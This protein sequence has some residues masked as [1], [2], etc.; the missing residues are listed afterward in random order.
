MYGA[1]NQKLYKELKLKEKFGGNPPFG[2]AAI[3]IEFAKAGYSVVLSEPNKNIMDEELWKRVEEAGVK[4]VDDDIEA[5]KHGEVNILF[6]PFGKLTVKIAKNIIKYVPENSIIATTCTLH[7]LILHYY[8]EPVLRTKRKDVGISS[9]H[10]AAVPGTELHKHYFIGGKT[11]DNQKLA[12]DEQ[13]N[14]LVE[15][16]KS[17]NKKP[18]VVPADILPAIADMGVLVTAVTLSG[19]LDYYTLGKNVLKAPEEMIEK[20]ILISLYTIASIIET[21]GIPGMVKALNPELIVESAK[22]MKLLD[23]QK[24]LDVAISILSNL[25]DDIKEKIEK[26]KINPTTLVA[27][28]CL[29]KEL[30]NM[31]GERAAKGMIR[32]SQRKL[33][34]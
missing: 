11:L 21:S 9:L 1:G 33:L 8:L 10:P 2:G 23:E 29:L 12:T 20:Q 16:C 22:S 25:N 30:V 3:A 17:V 5:A 31:V 19:I 7:P 4:I 28:Q 27:V 32:R 13:I 34:D 14:K 24:D 6:T 26:A 15:L 18:Y